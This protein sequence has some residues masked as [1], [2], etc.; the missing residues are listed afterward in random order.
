FQDPDRLP[1]RVH[2][3]LA[4]TT[5]PL[6]VV[7]AADAEP[8][9]PRAVKEGQD[10]LVDRRSA[11]DAGTA[12]QDKQTSRRR[13]RG[14]R[15]GRTA[16]RGADDRRGGGY[17][18]THDTPCPGQPSKPGPILL[19]AHSSVKP[20]PCG[21]PSRRTASIPRPSCRS[22]LPEYQIQYAASSNMRA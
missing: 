3:H 19:C 4:V 21:S 6:G 10:I 2:G 15:E 12:V 18:D 17:E 14:E 1:G 5:Y 11:E 16:A 7:E 9:L 20:L 13:S 22:L 8:E